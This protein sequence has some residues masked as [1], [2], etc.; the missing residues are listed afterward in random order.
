[1][2]T[3]M[4]AHQGQSMSPGQDPAWL[5]LKLMLQPRNK[6]R[7]AGQQIDPGTLFKLEDGAA[8]KEYAFHTRSLTAALAQCLTLPN[9]HS[10]A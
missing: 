10:H 7:C 9:K 5:N 2:N 6:H 1:M 8:V 4:M 3:H